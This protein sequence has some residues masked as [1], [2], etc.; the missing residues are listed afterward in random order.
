MRPLVASVAWGR[1]RCP[2][3]RR[4]GSAPLCSC[5]REGAKRVLVWGRRRG[6][7]GFCPP[8]TIHHRASGGLR[9]GPRHAPQNQALCRPEQ[10]SPRSKHG[11]GNVKGRPGRG[12][13]CG[14]R[15]PSRARRGTPSHIAPASL[16]G[17]RPGQSTERETKPWGKHARR[18]T[19]AGFNPLG[20]I[21]S[22]TPL[23]C[24]TLAGRRAPFPPKFVPGE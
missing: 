4:L 20:E 19:L 11:R 14:G 1:A 2:G 3:H 16:L 9:D 15:I 23:R 8:H 5:S 12:G 21:G 17:G 24:G 18:P 7:G 13:T 10:E 22:L 6:K